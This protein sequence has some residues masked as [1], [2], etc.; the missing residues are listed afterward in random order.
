MTEADELRAALRTA[1][2]G[3]LDTRDASGITVDDVAAAASVSRAD[4]DRAF[5]D[6]EHVFIAATLG[7]LEDGLRRVRPVAAQRGDLREIVHEAAC[8]ALEQVADQETFYRRVMEAPFKWSATAAIV[9]FVRT[10]IHEHPATFALLQRSSLPSCQAAGAI[11][12]GLVW[13]LAD[14]LTSPACGRPGVEVVAG[15]MTEFIL[16]NAAG[17]LPAAQ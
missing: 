7:R 17:D 8:A 12:S 6:L 10:A 3:L 15:W 5:D 2:A 16:R 4:F 14:W 11:A 1:A 13:M 9:D